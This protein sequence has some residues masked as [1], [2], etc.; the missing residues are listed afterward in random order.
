MLLKLSS[1]I[2]TFIVYTVLN[3]HFQFLSTVEYVIFAN[4]SVIVCPWAVM[5]NMIDMCEMSSSVIITCYDQVWMLHVWQFM[6]FINGILL[7]GFQSLP[8]INHEDKKDLKD[9]ITEA[10]DFVLTVKYIVFIKSTFADEVC[11]PVCCWELTWQHWLYYNV[12]LISI[13]TFCR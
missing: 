4:A 7:L 2:F 12:I 5:L 6:L 3:I 11:G 13:C 8:I 10:I 9:Q 1:V